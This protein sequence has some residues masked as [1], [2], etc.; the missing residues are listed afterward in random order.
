M[1]EWQ[2]G[3]T[4]SEPLKDVFNGQEVE[5]WPRVTWSP[6]WALIFKDVREKVNNK[7]SITQK[8][9]LVVNGQK[10]SLDGLNLDGTL[11]INA[12]DGA[13]VVF[14]NLIPPLIYTISCLLWSML[15]ILLLLLFV[16]VILIF[17]FMVF[18]CF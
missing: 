10:V 5:V 8:S 2:A 14:F 9:A 1:Y 12:A 11:I 4:I 3:L 16:I 7:C 17:I 15:L 18:C 13:E 6:K